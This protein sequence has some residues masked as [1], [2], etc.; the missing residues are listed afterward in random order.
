[1]PRVHLPGLS[2][3]R[4]KTA[5][6]A[7]RSFTSRPLARQL[8]L[9]LFIVQ[10]VVLVFTVR[11]G[12]PPDEQNN[13][14]FV[15]YYAHHSVSPFF[16]H[17]TPTYSLG[18]KTREIDY[19]YHYLMS[20]V[21]RVLPFSQP[22]E[23]KIIRLFSVLFAVLTIWVLVRLLQRLKVSE[24]AINSSLL[25]LTNLPMVLLLSAAVNND[26]LVWLG[27]SLGLLLVLRLIEDPSPADVLWLFALCCLGGLAKRTLLPA[28]FIFGVT[29]LIIVM[30][31]WRS[32]LEKL[33]GTSSKRYFIVALIIAVLGLGLFT[34]RVGGNLIKY[35]SVQVTCEQ[36]DGTAAC[37]NFWTNIR[38]R[39]LLEQHQTSVMP[40]PEFVF[41]WTNDSF[42]NVV[43]IQTQFWRH[44]VKPARVLTPLLV[45]G[46]FVGL[47]YGLWYEK[48]HYKKE[49]ESRYRI[50]VFAV[51]TVFVL[52]QL[53]VNLSTYLHYKVYGVA[54]NGRY[55]IPSLL[56]LTGLAALYWSKMLKQRPSAL[57]LLGSL[58]VVATISGSGL[59]MMLR[60]TQF[61]RG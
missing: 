59:L 47:T 61:Y 35:H 54:L 32:L 50:Y 49:V 22:M 58:L 10:A 8:I 36:V 23:D 18:D 25:V 31:C 34:E 53:A 17:Q 12:T 3:Q 38:A 4:L 19:L 27:M 24:A 55:I 48:E 56:P 13:I 42:V 57:V 16:S 40:L 7:I 41:R 6:Q 52:V 1:M 37:Y 5:L 51:T 44:E 20:L 39:S 30:R 60:N 29:G 46:L 21:A 43:D 9:G 14:D 33:K 2:S 11:L 26:V 15:Q 28:C 45:L